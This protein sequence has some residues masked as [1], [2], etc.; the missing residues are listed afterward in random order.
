MVLDDAGRPGH[1]VRIAPLVALV[2]GEAGRERVAP[3]AAREVGRQRHDRARVD[4]AA[5][6]GADRHVGAQP[7]PDRVEKQLAQLGHRLGIRLGDGDRLRRPVAADRQRAAAP[8]QDVPAGQAPDP[9]EERAVDR[10][11]RAVRD[12]R[13]HGGGVGRAAPRHRL[14]Q[15]L[16]VGGEHEAVA[17]AQVQQRLLA[18]RVDGHRHRAVAG[19]V[20]GEGEHRVDAVKRP[21]APLTPRVQEHLGVGLGDE[22]VA[23]RLELGAALAVVVDLAVEDERQRAQAHRL[24][25]ALVEVDDR[26]AP[27]REAAVRAAPRGLP[28][29]TAP[30]HRRG[31]ALEHAGVRR[32]GADDAADAAHGRRG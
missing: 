16:D 29:G 22:R 14:L 18:E 5:Q 21:L 7:Q 1:R 3:V 11:H 30:G 19:V 20:D 2:A 23:E 15:R 27:E 4:P 9:R 12:E 10:R 24:H 17:V 26:Q 31:H 28:V 13:G 25:R 6:R 8:A 32:A